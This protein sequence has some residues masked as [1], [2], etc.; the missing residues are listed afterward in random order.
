MAQ[1]KE[2]LG[3]AGDGSWQHRSILSG[4]RLP[5]T[6]TLEEFDLAQSPQIPGSRIRILAEGLAIVACRQRKRVRFTAAAALV[7]QLVERNAN[8]VSA[9]CWHA[10]RGCNGL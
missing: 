1:R 3:S 8:R 7:S 10:G 5:R 2:E 9:E 4:Q 6:K